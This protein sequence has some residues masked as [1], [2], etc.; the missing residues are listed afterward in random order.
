MK[1]EKE[2]LLTLSGRELFDI[3]LSRNDEY[4]SVLLTARIEIGDALFPLLE[5]AER[6]GKKVTIFQDLDS[7]IL[8]GTI[9]VTIG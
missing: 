9:T 8:D 1:T 3:Y 7:D 4:S 6:L 5:K 2:Y